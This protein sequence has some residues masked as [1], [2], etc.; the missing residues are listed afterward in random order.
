MDEILRCAQNDGGVV[1]ASMIVDGSTAILI[2]LT[3][4]VLAA[5]CYL[6]AWRAR[7]LA[8]R[9]FASFVVACVLAFVG[10]IGTFGYAILGLDDFRNPNVP[11]SAAIVSNVI[12]WAICIGAWVVAARCVWFALR[13]N[14]AGL[15]KVSG[16]KE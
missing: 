2:L 4:V 9:R 11:R 6:I 13:S 7:G 3:V 10:W 12:M 8:I 1:E 5:G 14:M 15:P 16:V